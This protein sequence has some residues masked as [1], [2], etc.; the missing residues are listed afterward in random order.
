MEETQRYSPDPTLSPVQHQVLS[1]LAQGVSTTEAAA[2]AEIHRN[3]I[4]NWRR[5]VPAF[6]RELEFAARERSLFWHD[7]AAALA[8]KAIAVLNEILDDKTASPSLRLRAA[9]KVIAMAS[10]PQS[11]EVLPRICRSGSCIGQSTRLQDPRESE[12]RV[13]KPAQFR[14]TVRRQ[15]SKTDLENANR[16]RPRRGKNRKTCTKLHNSAQT[17]PQRPVPLQIRPQIQTLLRQ[18]PIPAPGRAASG[19]GKLTPSCNKTK[20]GIH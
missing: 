17:R 16:R 11:H 18:S 3:T 5:S 15:A 19:E 7:Q 12:A 8:E 1:L 14:T 13:R 2:A 4:A 10:D 20:S 6:A 9:F